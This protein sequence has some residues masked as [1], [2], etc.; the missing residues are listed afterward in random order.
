MIYSLIRYFY[1]KRKLFIIPKTITAKYRR[2]DATKEQS[3]ILMAGLARD[4]DDA[5]AVWDELYSEYGD[6]IYDYI[7]F[8]IKRQ[9][10][11][12]FR[13]RLFKLL[14]R[15]MGEQ[16]PQL[17]EYRRKST[18]RVNVDYRHKKDKL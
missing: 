12:T 1:P 18:P 6:E 4:L 13:E 8:S 17:M 5:Q 9:Y 3:I 11:F 7:E 10:T 16:E 2:D 15:M 14:R